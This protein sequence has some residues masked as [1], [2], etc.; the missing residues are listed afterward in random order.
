MY[1]VFSPR[2][3]LGNHYW[4]AFGIVTGFATTESLI[5]RSTLGAL[6]GS[7]VLVCAAVFFLFPLR[8][9]VISPDALR[10][11]TADMSARRRSSLVRIQWWDVHEIFVAWRDGVATLVVGRWVRPV[12]VRFPVARLETVGAELP[13]GYD[14]GRL[15]E[16]IGRI[17]PHVPVHRMEPT[18]LLLRTQRPYT[19]RPPQGRMRLVAI[20]VG[21]AV[22]TVAAIA[23]HYRVNS[24]TFFVIFA[25]FGI[26]QSMHGLEIGPRGVRVRRWDPR[27]AGWSTVTSIE[28]RD[29]GDHVEIEVTTAS[30]RKTTRRL[31]RARVDLDALEAA[32]RAY[33]PPRA[34]RLSW[35]RGDAGAA[36]FDQPRPRPEGF[37]S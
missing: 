31:P 4:Y 37:V 9:L 25:G 8:V 3:L 35:S 29:L 19:V 15:L 17:A 7:V 27:L 36:G 16:A 20:A 11:R 33:A 34:L 6:I 12:A 1:R 10:L 18:D 22:A 14:H 13:P 21:A 2:V 26:T 30:A 5:A 24:G 28:A 32:L 23:D